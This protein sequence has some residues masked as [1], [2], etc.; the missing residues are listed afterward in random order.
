ME[1]FFSSTSPFEHST[2]VV[3]QDSV[4]PYK[5][6]VFLVVDGIVAFAVGAD[7]I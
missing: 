1:L 7:I 6:E 3:G 2:L 5:N 4:Q